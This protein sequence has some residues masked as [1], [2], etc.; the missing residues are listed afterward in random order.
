MCWEGGA[1]ATR[2]VADFPGN[3]WGC[4]RCIRETA[5]M[6][7]GGPRRL[8]HPTWFHAFG[9]LKTGAGE[10]AFTFCLGDFDL[11]T[12]PRACARAGR[13]SSPSFSRRSRPCSALA[14]WSGNPGEPCRS[15]PQ[16]SASERPPSVSFRSHRH[17]SPWNKV[18][19]PFSFQD[20]V[21]GELEHL[22]ADRLPLRIW[23]RLTGSSALTNDVI[24]GQKLKW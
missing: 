7:L 11:P 4:S 17:S 16:K 24:D 20:F 13:A 18:L 5:W 23:A 22:S 9:I 21:L 14:P 3:E 12:S 10:V 19:A 2:R 1:V 8:N 15:P 6:G